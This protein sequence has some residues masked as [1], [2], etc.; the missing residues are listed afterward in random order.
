VSVRR[1]A[2]A[3]AAAVVAATALGLITGFAAIPALANTNAVPTSRAARYVVA[4]T[5]NT[6]KPS[7]CSTITLATKISGVTGTTGNDLLTAT[8]SAETIAGLAGNDC[9]LG[10]GGNDAIDGGTGTDICIGG[11]GTDTFTNCET[12]IQ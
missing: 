4:I 6:L 11:P 2:G 9:I 3:A 10:G 8:A 12:A 5:A 7:S 1:I